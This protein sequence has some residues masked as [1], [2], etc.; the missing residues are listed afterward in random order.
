V[1][2]EDGDYQVNRLDPAL[3][4]RFLGVTV[5]A[6][7][8]E[9]LAWAA[10]HSVH[11]VVS[12]TVRDHTDAF[13]HVSPRS[14]AY[15]SELLHA[16]RQGEQTNRELVHALMPGYLPASWA[17]L[18]TDSVARYATAFPPASPEPDLATLLAPDGPQALAAVVRAL[19]D[20]QRIDAI[21]MLASKLREQLAGNVLL[22]SRAP[23]RTRDQLL[24]H[25]ANVFASLPGD[26]REQCLETAARS[27]DREA[28]RKARG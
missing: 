24:E 3:R 17:V 23:L 27:L 11:P 19:G 5:A 21:T 1:N 8:G 15:A 10:R 16:L 26:L 2:P 25:L 20:A 12:E 9:W 4:S 28:H 22:D 14:W 7:R 13:G 18:V 6:D